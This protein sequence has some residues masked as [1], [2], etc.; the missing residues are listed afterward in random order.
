MNSWMLTP[1]LL[2]IMVIQN[3]H[4]KRIVHNL[5]SSDMETRGI[6]MTEED[7]LTQAAQCITQG[8][9]MGAMEI[10]ESYIAANSN[11]PSGYHG[12]AEAAM[13]EIQENGNMD[14][15]G[16]DR[17]N[18]GKIQSYL[19][20]AAG[21][22]S[23]N[24]E[25][26]ASY[27]NALIEF[28]RVPMAIREFQKLRVLGEKS[29]EVDVSFHLYEAARMLIDSINLKTNFDRSEQFA[30]QY[31]PIAIEFAILGLGFTSIEEAMEYIAT[32]E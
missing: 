11:D 4:K 17:I 21:L 9:F 8:N 29:D 32:E 19:R 3:N 28:D 20:K 14:D 22:D 16:N 13:F 26:L 1:L 25:Y 24:A 2:K 10:F 6:Q 31:T 7:I 18:E 23:D 30:R 15:K 5:M 12:W 27:A